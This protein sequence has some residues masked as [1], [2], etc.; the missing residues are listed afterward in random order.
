MKIKFIGATGGI[1]TGSSYLL[2]FAGLNILVDC[3]MFQGE[4]RVEKLN[5][6]PFPFDP[7][8]LDYVLLTHSHLDHVGLLPKLVK[9]GFIGKIIC[10]DAT[11]S[12][13]EIIMMD[14]AKIQEEDANYRS[15]NDSRESGTYSSN[16]EPLYTRDDIQA[17]MEKFAIYPVGE[18]VKINEEF[19]F[20]MR[21][22]GHILGSVAF[23]VWF[24]NNNGIEKKLVMS[25]DLGQTGA[26]IIKDPEFIREAD[27]VVMESTYGGRNHKDKNS[28]L[29]ELLAILQQ[30]SVEKSRVIIPTFAV[31][32]TQELLYEINLFV[33][34]KL[35]HGLKFF[36]DSPL[37]IKATEIFRAYKKY[38]DEDAMGMVRSG[39]DPF[40]F[41]GLEYVENVHESRKIA[42]E[43]AAVIMAGSGMCTGGRVLHHL[44][45][46]LPLKD[47]HILFVG[48]QV[49][50]T[51]GRRLIDGAK[52]VRI[53]GVEIEVRAQIHTLNGFSAHADQHD[54]LYWLRSF[55]HSP[56][57]VFI[58]HGDQTNRLAFAEKVKEELQLETVIPEPGEEYVLD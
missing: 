19:S 49:P 7:I 42:G 13:A 55:G 6:E 10:T 35:L 24:K 3:G 47:A 40:F 30:A 44:M 43:R 39:D 11:K 33:E 12:L 50:G 54:L 20:R 48:F 53:H 27:Y 52:M 25:G 45:N 32:R 46:T 4:E 34:K 29:L 2:E 21:E 38:Y 41:R 37:A 36:V 26:R 8:S 9:H 56:K 1:V 18:Q 16:I 57:K 31:E 51:L 58:T 28:T 14:A 23:E 5:F 15:S 22:A 17:V